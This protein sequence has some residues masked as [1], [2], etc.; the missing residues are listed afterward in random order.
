MAN[1]LEVSTETIVGVVFSLA[2][3]VGS[4]LATGEEVVNALLGAPGRLERWE[5]ALGPA[6]AAG[7]VAFV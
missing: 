1:A 5:L 7:A 6:G 3:A 4:L 2:P